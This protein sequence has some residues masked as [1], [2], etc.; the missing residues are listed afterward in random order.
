MGAPFYSKFVPFLAQCPNSSSS[1]Q[2]VDDTLPKESI[3]LCKTFTMACISAQTRKKCALY[4]CLKH[5]ALQ[6]EVDLHFRKNRP[7]SCGNS[8]FPLPNESLSSLNFPRRAPGSWLVACP[9]PACTDFGPPPLA[10]M[11]C[12]SFFSFCAMP[13]VVVALSMVLIVQRCLFLKC[14]Y[15]VRNSKFRL[16]RLLGAG[17]SPGEPIVDWRL[18][19]FLLARNCCLRLHLLQRLVLLAEFLRL[20]PCPCLPMGLLHSPS[21]RATRSNSSG[22]EK[23]CCACFASCGLSLSVVGPSRSARCKQGKR[24]EGTLPLV[25]AIFQTRILQHPTCGTQKHPTNHVFQVMCP[26][27]IFNKARVYSSTLFQNFQFWSKS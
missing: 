11:T 3:I 7:A 25:V 24:R 6:F 19:F 16:Q 5:L 4:Y 15:L 27:A 17:F 18:S 21:P 23:I 14:R 22:D 2:R 13:S 20:C 12:N 10:T 9:S 1:L 8:C 26:W